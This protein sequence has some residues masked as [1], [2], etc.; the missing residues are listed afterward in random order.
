[1]FL[2]SSILLSPNLGLWLNF[3]SVTKTKHEMYCSALQI[4]SVMVCQTW[5]STK[6]LLQGVTKKVWTVGRKKATK[7][8]FLL[9]CAFPF[10]QTV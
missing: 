9:P 6:A 10:S 5:K 1:M 8:C 2:S 3:S 4:S 7:I